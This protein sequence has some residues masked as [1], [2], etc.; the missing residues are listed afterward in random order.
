MHEQIDIDDN[1][2][3]RL[4]AIEGIIWDL[5]NTLY[6]LDEVL[7]EAFNLSVARAA[8][9][10]GVPLR[11]GEAAKLARKS[12]LENGYSGQVFIDDYGI[13]QRNLHFEFHGFLDETVIEKSQDT[14]ALFVTLA[15][16][17]VLVTHSARPWAQKV[18]AHLNL[19][20]WFPEKQIL[21]LEDYNFIYKHISGE[22]FDK[23]MS[24][25]ALA[26]EKVLI[27]E[28]TLKNLRIP[29][30]MGLMTCY[31]HHG[32]VPDVKPE[33]VDIMA[34]S[35]LELLGRLQQLQTDDRKTRLQRKSQ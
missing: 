8:I 32:A 13:S 18:L 19:Q 20:D 14:R 16:R 15:L 26:S 11:L 27:V 22:A 12:F 9:D 6:R 25:M 31:I 28:D 2:L 34:N 1:H 17:H 7:Q 29:H 35:A 21:A 5:D 33:F 10:A 4:T 3:K 23:A 30:E 24:I